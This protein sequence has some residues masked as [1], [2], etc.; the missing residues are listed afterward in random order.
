MQHVIFFDKP[1]KTWEEALP[2]GNGHLGSMVY[3]RTDSLQLQINE[4]SLWS[5]EPFKGADREKAYTHLDDLRK[6]I[7]NK[8]YKEAEKLLDKEFTNNGGGFDGA[9][10]S[11]YQ[12]FGDLYIKALSKFKKVK[13]YRR[14]LVLDEA[15]CSDS[16]YSN[17]VK[18]KREYFCSAPDDV[19]CIKISSDKKEFLS[20]DISYERKDIS[21]TDIKDDSYL[22][23]GYCDGDP[24]H[25][26][27]AGIFRV[28][29][30]GGKVYSVKDAVRVEKADTIYIYFTAATDYIPDASVGFK[31]GDPVAKC[32]DI[33]KRSVEKT[34]DEIK[35]C[36]IEDYKKQYDR[37]AIDISDGDYS[38]KPINSRLVSFAKKPDDRSLIELFFCY[39]KYLLLSSSRYENILPANLQGIWCNQYDPPWHCD[40]HVNINLQMNYW[41]AGPLNLVKCT[42]PLARFISH[43]P[44]NGAKT[45]KAYYN[46]P[47]WTL[48]TISNPWFWTS[49]GWGGG[50]SQYP[51]GG[52]W[53]CRHIVEYYN[54]TKDKSILEKY[55]EILKENCL[56]NIS[57][58]Y[59]N[60]DGYLM[61]NPATSPENSFRDDE[62][63]TGWVCRGTAMDIEMLYEN[64]TDMI[65][66]TNLLGR[67]E[68]LRKKLVM[69]RS[70]LLPL[71]TGKAG[72]LCEWQGDWDLNAPEM[73]HRHVSHLYGLHPG[74]MISP[75]KTPELADACRKT[76]ELRG[77]DGTGWSLAWKINFFAR[78]H[79]GDH[80][81]KLMNRLLRP[82]NGRKFLYLSGG[83]VYPNLFDAHPPFQIDGNFG[84]SAG[85]AEMLLQSHIDLGNGIFLINILPALPSSWKNGSFTRLLA[86]GNTEV[87]AVWKN[88]KLETAQVKSIKGSTTAVKGIY[89]VSPA[90]PCEYK[91]GITYINAVK[92]INY[93]LIPKGNE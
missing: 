38:D 56:F 2:L 17:G 91:D 77:D 54:F 82:V 7:N 18:I 66:I 16:F 69:L 27:F 39:G 22:F 29:A 93:T 71:K 37:S 47:G 68:E 3:G 78:L 41:G 81:L 9:Y 46:A 76:L 30:E 65:N 84:A 19:L 8:Q 23:E 35:N 15:V 64:F 55:Y 34:Y 12:T 70:R 25:M 63:N 5:G 13:D 4:I 44:E 36:H 45:A 88:N 60:E 21:R 87:S 33:L 42:D 51:L 53:L 79:D 6:L 57:I 83:G 26:R 72:Q 67:D 32:K 40:Y 20:F 73:K 28:A 49:P 48:Y 90:V 62:G 1:A 50:W 58:L 31:S 10:S 43:L 86:R 89:S 11:S 52:A 14:Q 85:I 61:T 80:A 74:T 24:S 75:E 59:E 92:D